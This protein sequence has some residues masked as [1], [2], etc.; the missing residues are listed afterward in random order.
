MGIDRDEV[1]Q[2][3]QQTTTGESGSQAGGGPAQSDMG[4][5]GGSRSGGGYR[6]AQ[7]QQNHQG[8]DRPATPS[9]PGQSR[10]EAFDEAQGGGRGPE[11]VSGA[12]EFAE[13]QQEHQDRGQG[14][15]EEE[16]EEP[17]GGA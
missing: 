5:P 10:G 16:Q 6:N 1:R 17:R 3:T 7:N 8:Q 9:S 12:E 14:W 15:I 11:S 2:D 13:D 4:A